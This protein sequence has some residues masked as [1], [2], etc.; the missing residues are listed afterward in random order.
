MGGEGQMDDCAPRLNEYP[1]GVAVINFPDFC[2]R[3]MD[4]RRLK[5]HRKSYSGYSPALSLSSCSQPHSK[6]S[7]PEVAGHI[8][9]SDVMQVYE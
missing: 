8:M 3:N 4:L 7:S 5:S 6:L 1:S 9:P 2:A